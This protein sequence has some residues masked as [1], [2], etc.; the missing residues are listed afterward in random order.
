MEDSN[1]NRQLAFSGK[2]SDYH[3]W[4]VRFLSYAHVKGV[5]G[6]FTGE[7][8]APPKSEILDPKQDTAKSIARQAN[9]HAYN[10]LTLCIKDDVSFNAIYCAVTKDLP[11]GDAKLAWENIKTL[12]KPIATARQHELEQ[13][14]NQCSLDRDSKNPDEWF[15]ELEHIRLQL[16]L[17]YQVKIEDNKV[18]SQILFN[19]KPHFYRTTIA[20][21]KRDMDRNPSSVTLA[22]VKEDYRQVFQQR[23][24][25]SS[26]SSEKAMVAST[27]KRFPPKPP[28][29]DCRHCGI[30]GHRA[31]DCWELSRNKSQRPPN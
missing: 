26:S 9:D 3:K 25:N 29:T 31:Q 6:I 5:K 12:F 19:T 16:A 11:D 15:A 17:D 13:Q 20:M 8:K 14:F 24:N 4:S 28:K 21:I 18:I 27:K 30:K 10:I 22:N 7:L 1:L 2:S 23:P